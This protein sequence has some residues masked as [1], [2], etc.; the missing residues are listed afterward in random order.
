MVLGTW[1]YDD[2]NNCRWFP[3]AKQTDPNTL[4]ISMPEP[5]PG[6]D[7]Y[8]W[9]FDCDEW[10]YAATYGMGVQDKYPQMIMARFGWWPGWEDW[11]ESFAAY[12]Y[13]EYFPGEK[14]TSLFPNGVRENYV[15]K[16]I[17]SIP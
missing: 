12:V 11:A 13:P 3:F 1:I 5:P 9:G 4:E 10:P 8:C 16:A 15:K 6:T 14:L 17:R 2:Q 7:P